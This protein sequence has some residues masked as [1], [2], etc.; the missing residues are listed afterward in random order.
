M[1]CHRRAVRLEHPP[2]LR[3]CSSVVEQRFRKPQVR[4]S[5]PRIGSMW[6][7]IA[8]FRIEPRTSGSK[9]YL[10]STSPGVCRFCGGE[11]PA[12]TFRKAAH[13]IPAALGNRY[14]LSRE[15]C[16]DC[17]AHGSA[18]EDALAARMTV[19]R[20]SS[21]IP[22]RKGGVKHRFGG[23][24]PSFIESDP[25]NNRIIVDR[26]IG[27]DSLDVQRT[28]DGVRYAIKVPAHRP[29]DAM[30]AVARVGLMLAPPTDLA[31][32]DHVRRWIRR[33]VVW[34]HAFMD[35]GFI[36]GTG[37]KDVVIGVDAHA[38]PQPGGAWFRIGIGYGTALLSLHLPGPDLK[39]SD[40]PLPTTG[41]SPYPPHEVSWIRVSTA[42]E[43]PLPA[44]HETIELHVPQLA[45]LPPPSDREIAE[46][47]YFRWL[48]RGGA[49]APEQA[50]Q[51][52]LDGEQQLLW[53]QVAGAPEPW[54]PMP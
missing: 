53:S 13:A 19:A 47:A 29:L 26:T 25:A 36:P 7:P 10:Q 28:R 54:P 15:E 51:D 32:W 41:K 38:A 2:S 5:Y 23:D 48:A 45:A 27:D 6:L 40:A 30:R 18:L 46:A 42:S 16:D 24:R 50:L 11:A 17:N 14:L 44:R 22:G 20:V 12:A 4:G 9:T 21:R 33:E 35:E 49:N 37:L 43:E 1:A 39:L 8:Y 52:W 3:R 34:P 31:A